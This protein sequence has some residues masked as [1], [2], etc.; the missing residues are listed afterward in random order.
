[1]SKQKF[2]TMIPY[3][4]EDVG[5]VLTIQENGSLG[6][7]KGGGN[8]G[9]GGG[10]LSVLFKWQPGEQYTCNMTHTEVAEALVAGVPILFFWRYVDETDYITKPITSVEYYSE[11]DIICFNNDGF[12][13]NWYADGSFESSELPN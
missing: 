7:D 10:I 4:T 11:D 8:G 5:S 1:M 9:G 12:S 13:V 3:N 6:W 2:A